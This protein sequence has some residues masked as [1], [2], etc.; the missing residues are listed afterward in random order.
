MAE[1]CLGDNEEWFPDQ[2]RDSI[3]HILSMVGELGEVCNIIKKIQRGSLTM[4]EAKDHLH[5]EM[6]D[7]LIYWMSAAAIMGINIEEVYN[8][9]R[10]VNESR[11]GNGH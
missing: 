2:A 6:I 7:V 11:F 8:D 10:R 1:Q 9:K 3:H 4:A 5:E